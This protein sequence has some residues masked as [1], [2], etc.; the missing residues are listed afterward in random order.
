MDTK[1]LKII[2]IV[3]LI[4]L[5]VVMLIP[6]V[7]W[8]YIKK[9]PELAPNTHLSTYVTKIVDEKGEDRQ[10]LE[11]EY[12]ENAEGNG[13]R[14]LEIGFNYYSGMDAKAVIMN[15]VQYS[16]KDEY[17]EIND[18]TV[19]HY[20]K[21]GAASWKPVQQFDIADKMYVTIADKLF[22]LQLSGEKIE[23]HERFNFLKSVKNF[24][25]WGFANEKYK[26]NIK[27][28][29][30]AFTTTTTSR[31]YTMDDFYEALFNSVT[32]NN[33]EYG[34]NIL[35]LVD[36]SNY[37]TIFEERDGE[38][39]NLTDNQDYRAEYFAIKVTK[40]RGGLLRADDSNFDIFA[41]D[42][43]FTLV[44]T[45]DIFNDYTQIEQDIV[46]TY[47]DFDFKLCANYGGYVAVLSDVAHNNLK[48]ANPIAV[49]I[50]LD[51]SD[52]YFYGADK[53]VIGI[54]YDFANIAQIILTFE[55][56]DYPV[57]YEFYSSTV[58][59]KYLPNANA[60]RVYNRGGD[61]YGIT[62]FLEV[63]LNG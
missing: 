36:L 61:G 44:E 60:Y 13:K 22:A 63:Q 54:L 37:F 47:D 50:N 45:D 29:S 24:F 26:I 31:P 15:G 52:A 30:W 32:I 57:F 59:R 53:P 14:V 21:D 28:K 56:Y 20:T 3:I 2:G 16:F 6:D 5:T 11:L 27:D 9:H 1:K 40:H 4:L 43:D 38:F 19:Y 23:Y 10:F 46:L 8:L 17:D 58:G 34:S 7:I 39:V 12:W 49:S 55:Q 51:L 41:N 33:V 42:A 35:S 48:A 18:A 62:N 25:R